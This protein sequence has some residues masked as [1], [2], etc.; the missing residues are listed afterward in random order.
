MGGGVGGKRSE[1]IEKLKRASV[2]PVISKVQVR[3]NTCKAIKPANCERK[4]R[5]SWPGEWLS[6]ERCN[7]EIPHGFPA[8]VNIHV[9]KLV[10]E[11]SRKTSKES[12]FAE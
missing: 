12:V 8:L 5:G 9:T 6:R 10:P 2:R 3:E 4:R 7:F 11:A 1:V